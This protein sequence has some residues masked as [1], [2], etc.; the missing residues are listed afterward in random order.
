MKRFSGF[1]IQPPLSTG[2]SIFPATIDLADRAI[3]PNKVR[4]AALYEGS[5]SA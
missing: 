2:L 4:D 5:G 3:P 1:F